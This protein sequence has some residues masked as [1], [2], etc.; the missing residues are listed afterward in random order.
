MKARR[1]GCLF[2]RKFVLLSSLRDG[3]K[4]NAES[5]NNDGVVSVDDWTTV[6]VKKQVG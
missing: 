5:A 4:K 6:V 1:E 2:A 3:E